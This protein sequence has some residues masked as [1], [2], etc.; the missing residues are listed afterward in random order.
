MEIGQSIYDETRKVKP[1]KIYLTQE[2]SRVIFGE[3]VKKE[4]IMKANM[5][6]VNAICG[7]G[8]VSAKHIVE[9]KAMGFAKDRN[10]GV[11]T[12]LSWDREALKK[13]TPIELLQIYEWGNNA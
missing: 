1:N 10:L 5:L 7:R 9:M 4:K 2:Q 8:F 12:E 6:L 11:F 13:L 3:S